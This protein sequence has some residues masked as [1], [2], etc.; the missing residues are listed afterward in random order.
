MANSVPP[1]LNAGSSQTGALAALYHDNL[2]EADPISKE[3][4]VVHFANLLVKGLGYAFSNGGIP[5]IEAAESTQFLK[6]D[7]DTI[8]AIKKDAAEYMDNVGK[9]LF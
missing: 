3:L 2:R 9:V 7:P 8:A 1:C 5:E 6:I 4:L